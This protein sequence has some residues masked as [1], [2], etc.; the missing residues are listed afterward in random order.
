MTTSIENMEGIQFLTHKVADDSV[1]LIVT[2]PPYITSRDSG[3]NSLYDG[4]Q[5]GSCEKSESDWLAFQQMSSST[6]SEKQKSNY[7]KYGS[8]YGSKYAVK[9]QYGDWDSKFTMETLDVFIGL[10]YKKL[11]KGGTCI[12]FFDLWK[13]TPLKA[14]M[15]KHNF[16]QIRMI[17]WIKTNPQPLNSKI[18]YLTNC[19][20]IA[21]LGVK[22]G[23]PV[24]HS[25]Y[26]NGIYYHPIQGGKSRCHP[27]QKN[28][29]LFEE[30]I[31]KHSNEGDTVLDPFLGSGTTLFA[32]LKT[33]RT[34]IGCELN[35][36]YYETMINK[37]NT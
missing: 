24:F 8:I 36:H 3:M 33:R 30:L 23:K 15:E 1:H 9:T 17:E 10:F 31:A 18:N 12:V 13:I 34:C 4:I 37:I 14:L 21:L 25:S 11:K 32:C 28:A 26:D 35:T 7:L 2:D 22:G 20:E 29:V 6:F 27:T 19:R 5:N 16:K